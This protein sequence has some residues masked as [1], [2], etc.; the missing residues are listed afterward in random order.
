MVVRDTLASASTL[1]TPALSVALVAE[2]KLAKRI[3]RVLDDEDLGAALQ[4]RSLD[5]LSTSSVE[6]T[7]VVMATSA[8]GAELTGAVDGLRTKLPEAHLVLVTPSATRRTVQTLFANRVDALVLESEVE[9]CLGHAVRSVSA[10]QV[11]FPQS[12][13]GDF[14]KPVLSTREK[15]VL[16]MV[17][18]GFTNREI[19]SKLH[20]AE[21]TVKSHL[22]S[23][24]S[25]LDVR[26]RSEAAALILD[27]ATGLGTGILA[28]SDDAA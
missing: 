16:G 7:V 1:E 19:A 27:P 21:S 18:L 5:R 14:G 8:A 23:S 2:G 6:P 26:S 15:Q 25:K 28:I 22:S 24:F 11:S 3:A 12:L 9:V 20:L 4:V 10:G 13:R 17:V